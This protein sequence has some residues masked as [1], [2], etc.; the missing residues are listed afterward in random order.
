MRAPPYKFLSLPNLLTYLSVAAA[1]YAMLAV[2]GPEG[3]PLA[4]LCIGLS[5]IADAFD[6]RFASLFQRSEEEQRFGGQIDSLAD[7]IAFGITPPICLFQITAPGGPERWPWLVIG[8]FYALCAITRLAYFNLSLDDDE[9]KTGF[10][11]VPTTLLGLFW[12][13]FLLAPAGPW[14]AATCLALGGGA[15]VSSIKIGRPSLALRAVLF[16]A[17]LAGCIAHA[18]A[19]RALP[20]RPQ[21][22]LPAGTLHSAAWQHT[23]P[24]QLS[25]PPH[26]NSQLAP[27]QPPPLLHAPSP[28]HCTT[29][30]PAL[31]FTAPAQLDSPVHRMSQAPP[32]QLTPAAQALSPPHSTLP[33]CPFTST[34]PSQLSSPVHAT[35]QSAVPHCT[36]PPQD[37]SP[38]HCTWQLT[39]PPQSTPPPQLSSPHFT[40][41]ATPGGQVTL[42]PAQAPGAVQSTSH[43]PAPSH[44]PA[45]PQSCWHSSEPPPVPP[46]PPGPPP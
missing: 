43:T 35:A 30:V 31:L 29:V 10:V 38:S 5:A 1:A 44:T 33:S 8:L 39:A 36:L 12:T 28:E 6:G 2:R 16:L 4:G 18:F 22:H 34:P 32:S 46:A 40:R 7:A 24:A 20:A 14:V 11:G 3:R 42:P 15:M 21:L 27:T 45:S 23:E 25:A 26:W 37:P 17:A 9:G 41:H 13:L 19:L